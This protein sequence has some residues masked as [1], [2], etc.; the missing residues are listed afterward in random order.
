MRKTIRLTGR[1]QLPVGSFDF[2]IT[3]REEKQT[4][5]LTILDQNCLKGFSPSA[6]IKVRLSENKSVE[7]L[8]FGTVHQPSSATSVQSK[9]LAPSCQIRVAD[10][11]QT[12]QGKL[13]GSTKTW[14]YK[15]D[16]QIDGILL[17]QESPHIAPKLWQLEV[18]E[19]EHPIVYVNDS[20]PE[21]GMWARHDHVFHS[22]IWPTV[23]SK[24]FEKILEQDAPPEEGW[25]L[26]WMHWAEALA[27]IETALFSESSNKKAEWIDDLTIAFMRKHDFMKHVIKQISS[28]ANK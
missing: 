23:I 25:M 26:D 6:E 10:T 19:D 28:G 24:V 13:L 3:E 15:S 18:R 16:G 5:I 12:N 4:A 7:I 2:Q 14:T 27:P 8:R 20:V 17:F 22:C 21:A 11:A 1:R 9:F